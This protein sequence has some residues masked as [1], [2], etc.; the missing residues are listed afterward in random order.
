MEGISQKTDTWPTEG[1]GKQK[2]ESD[3][4]IYFLSI[5][6]IVCLLIFA[7]LAL[8]SVIGG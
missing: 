5:G 2:E 1:N 7:I 8:R 3:A 4:H 6:Y